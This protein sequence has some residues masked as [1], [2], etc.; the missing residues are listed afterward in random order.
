MVME[1]NV[2]QP[3]KANLPMVVMVLGMVADVRALQYQ[4]A[5]SLI[6][7]TWL[8]ILTDFLAGGQHISVDVSLLYTIPSME[9]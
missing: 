1:V 8:G 2:V 6:A 9:A 3:K 5:R 4:K 7:V